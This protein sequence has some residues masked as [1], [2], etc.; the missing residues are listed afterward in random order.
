MILSTW[1]NHPAS[2]RM[3]ASTTI[4]GGTGGEADKLRNFS[5]NLDSIL[6]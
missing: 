5:F 2:I 4:I 1:V 6:G 3:A